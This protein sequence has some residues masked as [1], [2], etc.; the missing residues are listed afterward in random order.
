M[1]HQILEIS[2]NIVNLL[3]VNRL[4]EALHNCAA[5]QEALALGGIRTRVYT[6]SH[7]RIAD[8]APDYGFIAVYLRIA[9]GRSEEVRKDMGTKLMDCL[10]A[11]V[12]EHLG[13]AP[14]ALSYEVQ[15]IKKDMRWN[16]NRV[17]E[18]MNAGEDTS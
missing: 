14:I 16:R 1:P 3:D 7:T 13:N 11:F 10:C 15:E 8:N 4:V 18:F 6:A 5:E 17:P 2:P 9:E 12:D